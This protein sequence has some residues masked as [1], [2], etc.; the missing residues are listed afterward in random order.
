MPLGK[1]QLPPTCCDNLPANIT[2]ALEEMMDNLK[3]LK[4][5][6]EEA[7]KQKGQG[8]PP[9]ELPPQPPAT[10]FKDLIRNLVKEKCGGEEH[11][12]PDGCEPGFE[13]FLTGYTTPIKIISIIVS[14]L[15]LAAII[16][17]CIVAPRL[18]KIK[19]NVVQKDAVQE[20]AVQENDAEKTDAEKTDAEKADA[21]KAA[22]QKK[23]SRSNTQLEQ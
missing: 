3:K 6:A 17:A 19:K 9:P 16:F 20:N 13:K 12:Y 2:D 8:G 11:I 14:I 5:E 7:M 15:Q 10:N 21:E 23:K 22:A 18:S 4:A 1:N